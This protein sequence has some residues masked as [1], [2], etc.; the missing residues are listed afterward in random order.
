MDN[1]N[2]NLEALGL[3]E[4]EIAIV[5]K[6]KELS[7]SDFQARLKS[8][9]A[10]ELKADESFINEITE[11]IKG[12]IIGKQKQ[13]AKILRNT[14]ELPLDSK[15]VES[16]DFEEL[17]KKAKETLGSTIKKDDAELK[18]QIIKEIEAR[19]KLEEDY[20][21]QIKD[22]EDVYQNKLN[23][24]DILNK[25]IELSEGNEMIAKENASY[26]ANAYFKLKKAEGCVFVLD[27]KKHLHITD[28]KGLPVKDEK[29]NIVTANKDITDFVLKFSNGVKPK[30]TNNNSSPNN[31]KNPFLENLGKGFSGVGA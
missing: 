20:K 9:I 28:E 16:M 7:V 2:K 3:T 12:Q 29:G 19:E 6:D 4:D 31:S 23:E 26:T 15:T 24:R 21:K 17:A 30:G 27:E 11:P 1:L 10:K 14:F 13:L 8:N 5:K 22:I 25:L 18:A